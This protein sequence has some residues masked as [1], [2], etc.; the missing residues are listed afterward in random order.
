VTDG[1]LWHFVPRF[2]RNG[3]KWLVNANKPANFGLPG[4]K[5]DP[6]VGTKGAGQERM[7][8]VG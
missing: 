7:G 8:M 3:G 4:T 5:A 6:W 1:P 2:A